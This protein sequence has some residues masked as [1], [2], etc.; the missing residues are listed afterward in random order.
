MYN[1]L[2]QDDNCNEDK[3]DLKPSDVTLLKDEPWDRDLGYD[4]LP[5]DELSLH[6][7]IHSTLLLLAQQRLG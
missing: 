7:G 6:Q 2:Q 1:S 5:E 4:E 3:S